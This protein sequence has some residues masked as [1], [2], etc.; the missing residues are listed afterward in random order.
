[1]HIHRLPSESTMHVC[2]TLSTDHLP[3]YES[4]NDMAGSKESLHLTA[5][6][7]RQTFLNWAPT[8][9]WE[10]RRRPAE[11]ACGAAVLYPGLL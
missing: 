10:Q 7:R 1:M 5:C 3:R 2:G 9:N 11:L 8:L 6:H 4:W